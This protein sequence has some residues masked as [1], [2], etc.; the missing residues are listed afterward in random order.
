[1]KNAP[2]EVGLPTI[3]EVSNK[4]YGSTGIRKDHHLGFRYTLKVLGNPAIWLMAFGLFALNI[5]R[6]GFMV[7]APS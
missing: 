3:E 7:W 6:Y 2:E 1:V 5:V 4:N